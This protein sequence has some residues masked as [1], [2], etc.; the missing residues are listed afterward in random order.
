MNGRRVVL[1]VITISVILLISYANACLSQ[2]YKFRVPR[3]LMDVS[4]EPDSS[5]IISYDIH[6]QNEP[7]GHPI[8]FIDIGMPNP[9]Y[10]FSTIEA[11]IDGVQISSYGTSQYVN[12]GIEFQL[13]ESQI[14]AGKYGRFQMLVKVNNLI[15]QDRTRS[16]Y[17]SFKI[18]PTWFGS[19][20][21]R[22]KSA[23]TIR[24]ALPEGVKPDEA[25]YQEEAF[26]D[27]RVEEG[28]TVVEWKDEYRFTDDHMVGVSFPKRTV[29]SVITLTTREMLSRW[30]EGNKG[31]LSIPIVIITFV[32]AG[33][34][35][36]RALG[37]NGVPPIL[38]M[39]FVYW[40]IKGMIG[41]IIPLVL[42]IVMAFLVEVL[43]FF[44]RPT[45]LPAIASV[46]SGGIKRGLTAP[47]AAALLE[48][49]QTKLI[50][51][52]LFGLLKKGLI[53]KRE[54]GEYAADASAAKDA[55]L[56]PYETTALKLLKAPHDWPPDKPYLTSNIDFASLV[57]ELGELV[58][59][60]MKGH[61]VE[62]TKEYYKQ[63]VERA[64]VQAKETQDVATKNKEIDEKIDWMMIDSD[65]ENRFRTHGG[66][67][68][69]GWQTRVFTGGSR[70]PMPAETSGGSTPRVSD[71]AGSLAGW[72]ESTAGS[73]T[74]SLTGTARP[75]FDLPDKGSSGG[76][77][78]RSGG[79]GS[80]AC[81]CAGCACACACAGGGR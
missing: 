49:P 51:L 22:G 17:A 62:E 32:L 6:F 13:G 14:P 43:R 65:F 67:Y 35:F 2:D 52:V 77:G 75:L 53:T 56:H 80:C 50:A 42:V 28:R 10:D 33:F 36:I 39:L 70:V 47:E 72:M 66:N 69:P 27:K 59:S 9:D 79:G 20:F 81:A 68:S 41:P 4:I 29:Q 54:N 26:T 8:D 71:I 37:K 58:A 57:K 74:S 55:A 64:W 60:R 40:N 5:A 19:D 24:I 44:R 48:L 18:T 7:S 16:D 61:N 76:G 63:I 46:E 23:V 45:Y 30:Y 3:V 15:F 31:W 78:G 34:A 12:P 11:Y 21:V 25:L 73:V 1:R 38:I